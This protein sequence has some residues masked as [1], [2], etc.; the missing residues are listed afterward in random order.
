M[1]HFNSALTSLFDLL[2]SSFQSLHPFWS[3]LILSLPTAILILFIFRYTSNQNGI[4]ETKSKI[5]AHL[6]EIRIYNDDLWILLSAQKK[7]LIYTLKYL[8]YIPKPMFFIILPLAIILIQLDGWFGNRP[9]KPGESAII[10][11]KISDHNADYIKNIN[12]EAEKGLVV[13]T[14][15]LRLSNEKEINWR[16]RA[17]EV[18]EHNLIFDISGDKFRKS[19]IVSNGE[20]RRV[21][22]MVASSLWDTFL[23]PGEKPVANSIVKKIEV[24]YP[25]RTIDILGWEFHWLLV[26]FVLTMIFGFG[27]K[28]LLRVDF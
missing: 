12:I 8:K 21:S 1:W 11:L 13:E 27:L 2:L 10:S 25:S 24:D 19:V 9:L 7:I 4:K 6:L 15:P 16:V 18:G 3:L 23:N 17:N 5:R 28:G 14:L 22:P 26:F 20:F